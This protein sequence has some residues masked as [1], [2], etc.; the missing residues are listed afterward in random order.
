MPKVSELPVAST[1]D[2]LEL[3]HVVQA[4]SKKAT[5]TDIKN[6][7][8]AATASIDYLTMSPQGSLANSR[9]LAASTTVTLNTATPGL[10]TFERAAFT[11]D[12]TASA[13][14][15]ALTIANLAV[16]E[17][18]LANLS[19]TNAK[20]ATDA[21]GTGKVID[22]AITTGKLANAAVTTA[23]LA[24]E[25]V[26]N[27]ILAAMNGNTLKGNNTAV[28]AVPVDIA[29]AQNRL[30][31]RGST[32]NIGEILLGTNLSFSGN[33]LNATGGSGGAPTDAVYGL[34]VAHANLPNA[35]VLTS[36]T[37]V[38]VDLTTAGQIIF[39]RAALTGAVL[40][41]ADSNV[42]S[43]AN[44]SV[45]TAHIQINAVGN[46]R[47]ADI[48][49]CGI[50]CN[51]TGLT[52]DPQD[53]VLAAGRLF[54]RGPTGLLTGI[55]IGAGLSLTDTTLS[56]TGGGGVGGTIIEVTSWHDLVNGYPV[57]TNAGNGALVKNMGNNQIPIPCEAFCDGVNWRMVSGASVLAKLA[58]KRA[59]TSPAATWTGSYTLAQGAG[60][61]GQVKI[62]G[63]G[64]HALTSGNTVTNNA[65][66]R[67]TGNT[68]GT[69]AWIPGN[70]RVVN[71]GGPNELTIE[72]PYS[73]S[74]G[75]PIF[76]LA[77]TEFEIDRVKLPRI[78]PNVDGFVRWSISHHYTGTGSKRLRA[79]HTTSG[80]AIGGIAFVDLN[81]V[82]GSQAHTLGGF[83][84]VDA[85]N[86]HA[87]FGATS[88]GG[89]GT[90]ATVPLT[91]TVNTDV[92]NGTD[93]ILTAQIAVADELLFLDRY[94][95]EV[96]I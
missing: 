43:L 24:N 60:G 84:C 2:G 55:T 8:N 77:N 5:L 59:Y 94:I 18:K 73:A 75:Q 13:N 67:V 74:L 37:G 87:F 49:S 62:T 58:P 90:Q 70:Y 27:A 52:A 3:V 29:I 4:G 66:I 63:T 25:A 6:F 46:Q 72:Y 19:V 21:V 95:F 68:G 45:A 76:A 30:F 23:K 38:T 22:L 93:L 65:H 79:R 14:S 53:Y 78:G 51:T 1:L 36:G 34:T 16:T 92:A 56:A 81:D 35:R 82:T 50:K 54:G 61:A 33:T 48:P 15:N 31:G 57:A 17:A 41:D 32:G 40:A 85:N 64:A 86:Q 80:G 12:V 44:D 88:N 20:L 28:G 9:S 26:T 42:T 71:I 39:R 83:H 7:I 10:L 89:T 11:G 47:A 91:G 69:V 96:G